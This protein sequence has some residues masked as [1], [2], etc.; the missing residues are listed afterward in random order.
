MLSS[1]KDLRDPNRIWERAFVDLGD[2][3]VSFP[4]SSGNFST[5]QSSMYVTL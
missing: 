3:D 5:L 1:I 2:V 4:L